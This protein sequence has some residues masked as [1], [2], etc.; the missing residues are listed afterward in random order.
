[1]SERDSK[2]WGELWELAYETRC[3][4]GLLP[5]AGV[6]RPGISPARVSAI[7]MRAAKEM[8]RLYREENERL[9][10]DIRRFGT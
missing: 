7:A 5:D 3:L 1:M 6:E 2:I 4:C 10:D 8:G 9:H